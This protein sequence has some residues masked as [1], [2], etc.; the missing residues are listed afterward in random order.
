MPA[1]DARGETVAKPSPLNA[2]L[3]PPWR[4]WV[5]GGVAAVAAIVFATQIPPADSAE[6]EWIYAGRVFPIETA[7]RIA[8][9]L[10]TASIPCTETGGRIGVP[11]HRKAEALALLVKN[12]LAPRSLEELLDEEPSAGA[13]FET[14]EQ[15]KARERRADAHFAAKLIGEIHGVTRAVVLFTPEQAG[16]ALRPE[17]HTKTTAFIETLGG[18]LLSSDRIEMIRNILL[19]FPNVDPADVTILNPSGNH[20]YLVAGQPQVESRTRLNGREEELQQ[21]ISA[22]LNIQGAQVTVRL[23][24]EEV[25][26]QDP[27]AK[28]NEPLGELTASN[29]SAQPNEPRLEVNHA[30]TATERERATVLVR[31]PRSHFL[32]RFEAEFPGATPTAEHMTPLVVEVRESIREVVRRHI[33]EEALA[34]LRIDRLE[35]LPEPKVADKRP[36]KP[37]AVAVPPWVPVG[38]GITLAVAVLGV[39]FGGWWAA[40]R[41]NLPA[42]HLP[43]PRSSVSRAL[44]QA[45]TLI[46]RDEASA[47][48]ALR[49]WIAQGGVAR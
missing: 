33:A 25:K 15:R 37:R 35:D 31:V 22:D 13:L 49:S 43:T 29:D 3:K 12:R 6:P 48:R 41:Q 40:R 27:I 28:V 36:V 17:T 30:T 32:K 45:Q 24:H 39:L 1:D 4:W 38:G 46:Q 42:P 19:S 2:L 47:A 5:I 44:H 9:V 18:Q 10:K 11:A 26:P 7:E 20:E 14:P 34:D 21:R 16:T 8:T 23:E